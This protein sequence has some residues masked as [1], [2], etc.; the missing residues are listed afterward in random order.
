MNVGR[1]NMTEVRGGGNEV[2]EP[3]GKDRILRRV[4]VWKI[5][6]VASKKRGEGTEKVVREVKDME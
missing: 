2:G 1:R 4:S 6:V 5:E 3:E